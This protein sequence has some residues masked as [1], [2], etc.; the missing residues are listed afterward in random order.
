MK[1]TIFG[2]GAERMV[3]KFREV[4]EG[5]RFIGPH[6]VAKESRFIEDINSKDHRKFHEIF[7]RTQ[8]KVGDECR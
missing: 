1:K 3:S 2:E 7:C 6:L 4:G 8:I 5:G